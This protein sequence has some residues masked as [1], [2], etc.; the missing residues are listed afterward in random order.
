MRDQCSLCAADLGWERAQTRGQLRAQPLSQKG[1]TTRRG[2]SPS[3]SER[4]LASPSGPVA[5]GS[6]IL[7]GALAA[8]A[9]TFLSL[10]A[11]A[12]SLPLVL[13]GPRARAELWLGVRVRPLLLGPEVGETIESCVL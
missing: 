9:N 3:K 11:P 6:T 12:P 7:S 10:S 4:S 1:S 2:D 13:P 5:T 8:N